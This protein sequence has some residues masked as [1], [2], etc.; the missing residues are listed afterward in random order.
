MS[1]RLFINLREKNG[2]TYNVGI[3]NMHY[4]TTGCFNII[5]SVDRDRLLDYKDTSGNSKPGAI[6]VLLDTL[7]ELVEKGTNKEELDKIKGFLKGSLSLELEDSQS[8]SDYNGRQV[9]LDY[10]E[11]IP[12]ESLYSIFKSIEKRDIEKVLRKVFCK[13]NLSLFLIGKKSYMDLER[14]NKLLEDF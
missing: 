13:K 10:P 9:L 12:M 14:I 3:D 2:L 4:E 7:K 6:P 8:I 11:F 1:S 5:T